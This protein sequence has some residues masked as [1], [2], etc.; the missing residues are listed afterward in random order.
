ME[1]THAEMYNTA[2]SCCITNTK[3]LL[4]G[5]T[6]REYRNKL[7]KQEQQRVTRTMP[8]DTYRRWPMG[9]VVLNLEELLG[10]VVML[11]PRIGRH[12]VI[13]RRIYILFICTKARVYSY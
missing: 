11:R 10:I 3:R 1:A 12:P 2:A 5:L 6:I 9:N 4:G 7:P 8:F 13:G